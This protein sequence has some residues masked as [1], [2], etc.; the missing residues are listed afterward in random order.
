[1]ADKITL[2]AG[3]AAALVLMAAPAT[4]QVLGDDEIIVTGEKR[5][6][7]LQDTQASVAVINEEA[8]RNLGIQSFR[9]AFRLSANVLDA[10]WSDAG[11]ILRG[12]N[13]E[14]LTPGGSPLAALYV[15]GAQ[16]TVQGARR[17]ARGAWDVSQIE[18]YR[19]PQSTLS[20]RAALAGAIYVTTNE[21]TY[22]WEVQANLLFGTKETIQGGVAFGGPLVEDQVA[23]R[24]AAEYQSEES[25]LDFGDYERYAR[26]AEFVD[27]EYYQVRGKLLV[28][29]NGLPGWR[30]LLTY[31]YAAD[32]PHYDDIAGPGLGFEYDERRG[33]LNASTPFFQ[34]AREG[35]VHNISFEL[36]KDLTESLTFTSLTTGS[37]SET[38][39][40]SINEGTVGEVFVT[41]GDID[42]RLITQEL[43]LNYD[44]GED[45]PSFV[46][47]LYFFQ[48]DTKSRTKRSTF[49][50]GG[51]TQASQADLDT[52]NY[53]AFGELTWPVLDSVDIIAGG[54]IQHEEQESAL[55]ASDGAFNPDLLPVPLATAEDSATTFLPKGSVVW[56]ITPEY[57]LGF[58]AARGFRAGGSFINPVTLEASSFDSES[59]WTY[60]V[61]FRSTL[62]NG[63]ATVNANAFY[64]DWKDQQVE[65]QL[66]P[67]DFQSTITANAGE[68]NLFGFE[69]EMQAELMDGLTGFA[70]VGY[71]DT[72]FEDFVTP[73][74]DF[75]GFPFPESPDWT[76]AAGFD[77]EHPSG[78]FLG[79]DGKYVEDYLARDIQNSP[80]DVVGDYLVAN[81]RAGYRSDNYTFMVFADNVADREYFVYRDLIDDFDC[82]GTLGA[83]RVVGVSI[84]ISY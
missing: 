22:D 76:L 79:A 48:E 11:F 34:E 9:D 51:R 27:D 66:T 7:T 59:T 63:A 69:L 71:V 47:G 54:R 17:G 68:S 4:G 6:R 36:T 65:F 64:T 73:T 72:E 3:S 18:I 13:S 77:Y 16:Q 25:D 46:A 55:F 1:M 19:G 33:D 53:A 37:Y 31:S 23:F 45:F 70:S 28:E 38:E 52:T 50:G 57:S 20:G 43:R 67:G 32:S 81:V 75:S 78:F 21:P 41:S 40:P 58:T 35:T 15:D 29:P 80:A 24:I 44:R 49:F 10:D 74:F 82:C 8:I 5:N 2:L 61:A 26:F 84:D 56:E 39:R 30:G 83:R 12:V 60:E 62:F 14:G 42:Q